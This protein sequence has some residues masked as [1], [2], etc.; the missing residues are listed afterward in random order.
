MT[1]FNPKVASFLYC[2]EMGSFW[3]YQAIYVHNILKTKTV[4]LL[5]T[6]KVNLDILTVYGQ[7]LPNSGIFL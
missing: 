4:L 5:N 7:I 1:N 3:Y 6:V 2:T